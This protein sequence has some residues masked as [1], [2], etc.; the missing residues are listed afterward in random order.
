MNVYTLID[1]F[2]NYELFRNI[3]IILIFLF[4]FL[5]LTIG[6]NIILA[7]F[8]AVI[9]ILYLTEKQNREVEVEKA[10]FNTK[11]ETIKPIP[12]VL[13]NDKDIIDFLI[14]SKS[15]ALIHKRHN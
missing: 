4:I 7:L 11:L 15:Q 14:V 1:S 3:V 6:L 2:D 8:L 12:Q 10:L 13:N 9:V 5:K